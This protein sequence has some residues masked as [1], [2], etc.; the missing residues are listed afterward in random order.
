MKLNSLYSEVIEIAR[1]LQ[2]LRV[3]CLVTVGGGSLID[4]GKAA[5]LV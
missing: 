4:G 3:D 5:M 1:E 2:R